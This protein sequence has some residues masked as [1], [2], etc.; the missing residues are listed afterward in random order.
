MPTLTVLG[1]WGAP[2]RSGRVWEAGGAVPMPRGSRRPV[3]SSPRA[4]VALLPRAPDDQL[5]AG[6]ARLPLSSPRLRH[7][8]LYTA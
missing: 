7:L 6:K 3:A 5:C 4:P 8:S 2:G 1:G